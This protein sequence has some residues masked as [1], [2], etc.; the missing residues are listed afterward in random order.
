MDI[1]DYSSFDFSIFIC[2]TLLS[3][4]VAF[5]LT[6]LLFPENISSSLSGLPDLSTCEALSD[7]V[8][9][10]RKYDSGVLLGADGVQSLKLNSEFTERSGQFYTPQEIE[11]FQTSP[12]EGELSR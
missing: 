11:P 4:L 1:E 12:A 3:L 5:A 10:K 8:D 6:S 9:G 7:Q 2:F